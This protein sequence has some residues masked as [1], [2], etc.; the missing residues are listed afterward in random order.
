MS[1]PHFPITPDRL[2]GAWRFD[3]L[4]EGRHGVEGFDVVARDIPHH[5]GRTFGLR[6]SAGGRSFAYLSDHAPHDLG[7]GPHG[8][9]EYHAA[10]LELADGVDVLIHDAT[11][12]ACRAAP[13]GRS[14]VMLP[15][16]THH[17]S[18][19]VPGRG[20]CCCSTTIPDRTDDAVRVGVLRRPSREPVDLRS[21]WPT[22]D[23]R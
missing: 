4:A 10:A 1:P 13:R 21:T 22:R 20:A 12:T 23:W 16:S 11:L 18:P 15:P 17:T 6:V 9:G 8:V 5:G 3:A 19:I 2:R 7:G 14:S